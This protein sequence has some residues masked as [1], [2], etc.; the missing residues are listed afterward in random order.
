[1]RRLGPRALG[2]A[3]A[4]ELA[5]LRPATTLARVQEAWPEV[6]GPTIAEEAAPVSERAGSITFRC[7]SAVW[8]Q[9]LS[10][11]SLELAERLN[12]ELG[13]PPDGPVVRGLRFVV[14][15]RDGEP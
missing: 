12:G 6:A 7:R 2:D 4:G 3:V 13:A 8:A 15:G 11:L 5:R 10:L 9:E 1:M 14:G